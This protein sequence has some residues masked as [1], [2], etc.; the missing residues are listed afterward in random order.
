MEFKKCER[1]GCFFAS[2]DTI[3]QNCTPKDNFEKAK[4]K[5]YLENENCSNSIDSISIDTGI[6]VKNLNRHL[7]SKEFSTF[8]KQYNPLANVKL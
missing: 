1:C 2:N 8:S 7:G 4:L 6:S 5:T 3:C